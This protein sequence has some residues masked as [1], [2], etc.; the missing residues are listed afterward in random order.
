MATA[1]SSTGKSTLSEYEQKRAE[2][3]VRNNRRLRELGLISAI[4]EERSNAAALGLA[5]N[6]EVGHSDAKENKIDNESPKKK[7]KI[8]KNASPARKSARLR[9]ENPDGSLVSLPSPPEKKD[10]DTERREIV[11]E[12][13]LAR[14]RAALKVME[15]GA[16]KA[17]KENP[18]AT[19]EHCLMRV[20][21]MSDKALCTRV[22]VI[23]RA[24]GKHCVIKMAIFKSCLQDEDKWDI[25][26]KASEALERLKRLEAPPT[27][28]K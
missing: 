14:Q 12:C 6:S 13:R 16:D 20:R 28:G 8:A 24:A 17:A 23:E 4:E 21:T 5:P 2:N 27:K 25:A 18:T 3:V 10:R 9:G 7:R 19:Y 1:V 11:K 15:E 22:K 26:E